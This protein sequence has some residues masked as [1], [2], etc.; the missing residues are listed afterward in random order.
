MDFVSL[1]LHYFGLMRISI[2]FVAIAGLG[3]GCDEEG[4]GWTL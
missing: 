3:L 2:F 1:V 4:W